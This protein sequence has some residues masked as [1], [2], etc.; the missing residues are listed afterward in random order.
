MKSIIKDGSWRFSYKTCLSRFL[1]NKCYT[2]ENYKL[3]GREEE[4]NER[5]TNEISGEPWFVGKDVA[6][7]L[8]YE[9]PTKA[10][11]DHVDDDDRDA[12]PI[13][14]SIGRMQNTPVINESGLYSLVLSSKLPKAKDFKR[15]ITREVI[16]SICKQDIGGVQ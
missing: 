1:S 12:V 10:V 6:E 16:P 11:G 5:I 2:Q 4:V 15:W 9:R 7:A 3:L 14:D 8:G 13:Q